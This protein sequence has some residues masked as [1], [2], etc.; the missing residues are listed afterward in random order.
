MLTPHGSGASPV[1]SDVVLAGR[2][3]EREALSRLLTRAAVGF[4]GAL[5][6]RGEPGVG[7]GRA[8]RVAAAVAR[9]ATRAGRGAQSTFAQHCLAVL[10]PGLGNYRPG[11]RGARSAFSTTMPWSSAL[12]CCPA[13]SRRPHDAARPG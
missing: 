8:R 13:W 5:V 2:S 4:N 11:R 6:L 9:E 12:M 7:S 3:A 10:E 1:G